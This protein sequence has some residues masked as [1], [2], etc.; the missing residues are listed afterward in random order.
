MDINGVGK[1]H[2][3]NSILGEEVASKENPGESMTKVVMKCSHCE[4]D[5]QQFY[6]RVY[7][8]SRNEIHGPTRIRLKKVVFLNATDKGEK[9]H[10]KEQSRVFQLM[11]K[12]LSPADKTFKSVVAFQT[13]RQMADITIMAAELADQVND[14]FNAIDD[15][16]LSPAQTHAISKKQGIHALTGKKADEFGDCARINISLGYLESRRGGTHGSSSGADSRRE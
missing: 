13:H 5:S 15:M 2:M 8:L 16:D 12:R 6:A 4:P 10:E 1:V 11:K 7:F 3:I 14:A 9:V